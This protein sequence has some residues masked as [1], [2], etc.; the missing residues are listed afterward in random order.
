MRSLFLMDLL[1]K[2]VSNMIQFILMMS[3]PG[4]LFFVCVMVISTC[5]DCD[6]TRALDV[7]DNHFPI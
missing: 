5:S 4:V 6:R 2:N 1:V 3:V 7:R